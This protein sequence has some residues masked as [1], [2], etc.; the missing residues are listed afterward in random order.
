MAAGRRPGARPVIDTHGL[1]K[2]YGRTDALIDLTLRVEPGEIFGFL[3]PNGA[4]KTTA[5]KLLLGL[6]RA[7][8]GSGTVLGAPLGDSGGPPRDRLPARAV[9][10][11]AVAAGPRGA[12]A[13]RAAC[14]S[15]DGG[16]PRQLAAD[17]DAVL[18]DV[19]LADRADDAV[20]GFSKGM[21][22]RLGLAVALLGCAASGRPRRADVRARPGR[23]C[24]R[25][26]DR[27]ARRRCRLDDLPEQPPADRGRAGVRPRRDRRPR[28]GAGQ[29]A[30]RRPAR[31]VRRCGCASPTC[32]GGRCRR[33]RAGSG[34]SRPARTAGCRS[35]ASIPSG[36]RTW[37][38]R[39][40]RPAG[41]STRSSRAGRRSRTCSCGWSAA[42]VER[43]RG[44]RRARGMRAAHE[45]RWI[46]A[47][48]TVAE[49]ARRRILLGPARADAGQRRC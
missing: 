46:I 48:L 23:P 39:S 45:S 40:W 35:P 26:V 19:G 27:P 38:P 12:R 34:R 4:G 24:R 1:A 42:R 47:R 41:G 29:R 49:A 37:S 10:V 32:A 20:G 18:G 36:S 9:P 11:P 6:A 17:I 2:R 3:G 14:A 22:Q 7:T 44:E 31:R 5:V 16:G 15:V 25:P 21:Q 30:D 8:G 13:A 28:A 43:G 33:A